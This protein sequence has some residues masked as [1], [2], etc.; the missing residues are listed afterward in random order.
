MNVSVG[1]SDTHPTVGLGRFIRDS[2]FLSHNHQRDY[3][4]THEYVIA[5]LHDIEE[6]KKNPMPNLL[7]RIDGFYKDSA[8]SSESVGR[9]TTA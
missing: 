6:A 1:G 5:F 4:W 3:S 2:N 8:S 7:L 9:P